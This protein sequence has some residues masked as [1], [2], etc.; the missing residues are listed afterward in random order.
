[1]LLFWAISAILFAR[2]LSLV[3]IMFGTS[4]LQGVSLGAFGWEIGTWLCDCHPENLN[5]SSA[6]KFMPIAVPLNWRGVAWGQSVHY[7]GVW[8]LKGDSGAVDEW[9][10][11]EQVGG[12]GGEPVAAGVLVVQN[13]REA[14]VHCVLQ[15]LQLR[16]LFQA[17][18][19]NRYES[20]TI[21]PW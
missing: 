5:W 6:A 12:G 11:S 17:T 18:E 9:G 19:A 15:C 20:L 14:D 16:L 13:S 4:P 2:L 1:M 10:V 8:L 7:L 3:V 21:H